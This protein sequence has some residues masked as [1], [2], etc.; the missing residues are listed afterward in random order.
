MARRGNVLFDDFLDA[1][2]VRAVLNLLACRYCSR[3]S[4]MAG[5]NAS[6]SGETLQTDSDMKEMNSKGTG[7]NVPSPEKKNVRCVS[8]WMTSNQ[9][10]ISSN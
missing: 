1:M 6:P 10:E 9:S 4:G 7:S 3:E 2:S 8:K 5:M